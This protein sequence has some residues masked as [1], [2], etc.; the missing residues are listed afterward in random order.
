[1]V[2]PGRTDRL[3]ALVGWRRAS[4]EESIPLFRTWRSLP[5][6]AVAVAVIIAVHRWG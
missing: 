2:R 4:G 3:L 6:V 5:V 1:M